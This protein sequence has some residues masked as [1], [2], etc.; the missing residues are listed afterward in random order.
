MDALIDNISRIIVPAKSTLEIE[1]RFF[2]DE[3]KKDD[4]NTKGFN[5]TVTETIAKSLIKKYANKPSSISQTINFIAG[6]NVKQLSFNNGEQQKDK[7]IF[8]KKTKLI[9][10][11]MLLHNS[12]PACRF[13]VNFEMPTNEFPITNAKLARIRLRYSIELVDWKLEITLIK[14]ITDFS[15]PADLKRAKTEMLFPITVQSFPEKAPWS[16]ADMI[17]F[18]LEYTGLQSEFGLTKMI[19][20]NTIFDDVLE[21][22]SNSDDAVPSDY[23]NVIYEIAKLITPNDA[24]KFKHSNGLKQ[25]SNQVIELDKNMFLKDVIN[26]I[27]EYYITDKVDGKRCLVYITNTESYAVSDVL[28]KLEVKNPSTII[29]DTELYDSVYYVFDILVNDGKLLIHAPFEKR[30][31]IFVKTVEQLGEPF[32]LKP[33]IKL[34][35]DF[36]KQIKSFK[37]AKKPYDTDGIILTPSMGKYDTMTVYKYKPLDR[38]TI[39]FLIKKCPDKL[40]GISPYLPKTGKILYLLFSGIKHDVYR[41]LRMNTVRYYDDIFP[42]IDTHRLPKYMPVQFQASDKTYSYLFYSSDEKLD[43]QIGEFGYGSEWKLHH[44]REDRKVELARGNYFGNNY[45]V[46][47]MTWLSYQTPLVIEDLKVSNYFQEHDNILQKASR[48]FNSFVKGKIC[49]QFKDSNWLMDLASGKGQDLFRYSTANMKNVVF[50]EIDPVA[51]QELIYRKHEFSNNRLMNSMAIYTHQLDLNEDYKDNINRLADINIGSGNMDIIMCHFALH[52]LIA[53]KKAIV[54]IFKFVSYWLKPGGR[55]VFTTFDAKEI[56]KLLNEN[57]G[58]WTVRNTDNEIQY[59]IKKQYTVNFVESVGQQIDV[60]L[61][62]SKNKYY[63]EYL[64]NIDYIADEAAKLG[65]TLEIDQSFGEYLGEYEKTNKTGFH[66]MSNLDKKYSSLYH[67]YCFYKKANGG[68]R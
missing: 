61:P 65:F 41:Q 47:E 12:L 8:Y 57:H 56:I 4:F 31:E 52:Y 62:F 49:D 20:F 5:K 10:P 39:D 53:N 37:S 7:A 27:T 29:L 42:T 68:K 46:A 43:G 25:L 11:I 40:L 14:S 38:L 28:D 6:E 30:Y 51:L 2:I 16:L 55:F 44:I 45:K 1:A 60:L 21:N 15:N 19:I 54:N 36:Q 33:F 22:T 18:E 34:T 23:Q 13:S 17:E 35:E 66:S 67:Y 58:E 48:N 59:S 50:L 9:H 3:R 63:T 64:V 24:Y 26:D 32:K